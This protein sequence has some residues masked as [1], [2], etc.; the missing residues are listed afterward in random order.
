MVLE[1][2]TDKE[3]LVYA[4]LL[5]GAR[6]PYKFFNY[7]NRKAWVFS[8]QGVNYT[9]TK[10]ANDKFKNLLVCP[11]Y[12]VYS[13]AEKQC[14]IKLFKQPQQIDGLVLKSRFSSGF[15]LRLDDI[16]YLNSSTDYFRAVAPTYTKNEWKLLNQKE[17]SNFVIASA[18]QQES[19]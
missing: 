15:E 3:L 6:Y 7:V 5:E 16:T 18:L 4:P 9:P 14:V 13:L 10:F 11:H 17:L 19:A 8:S 2:E 12:F 1:P